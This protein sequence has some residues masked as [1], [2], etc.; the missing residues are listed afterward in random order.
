[1]PLEPVSYGSI[2]SLADFSPLAKIGEILQKQR[3]EDEAARLIAG[4][5][6]PQQQQQSGGF[7]SDLGR[8]FG[9]TAPQA[10]QP[11]TAAAPQA[12]PRFSNA[13]DLAANRGPNIQSWY[14]FARR[15]ADQGGLG[16]SHE[17]AV[18][19]VSNLQAESGAGI[20]A[21]GPTGDRGTAHGAAQWRLDRFANLQKFAQD[22]GLDYRD[23]ATQQ[24]FM[25]HEYLGSPDQGPGGGSE[26]SAYDRLAAA[27]TPQEAATAVNRYYERSADRTGGREANAARLAGTL[28]GGASAYAAPPT[29]NLPPEVAGGRSVANRVYEPGEASPFETGE[30]KSEPPQARI[31]N[32]DE[33]SPFETGQLTSEPPG[34]P[35]DVSAQS[36]AAPAANSVVGRAVNNLV[37]PEPTAAAGIPREQLAAL[38]RNPITRPLATAFL[39]KQLDPGSYSFHQVGDKLISSNSRTGQ[40]SVVMDDTKPFIVGEHALVRDPNSPTGFRDVAPPSQKPISVKEGEQLMV[41]D[42]NAPSGYRDITPGGGAG[43]SKIQR[44][45]RQ[46]TD[47]ALSKGYDQ[48]TADYYGL[49]GKLPK[50]DLSATEIKAISEAQKQVLSGQ[51][52]IDNLA[53]LK[54]LSP[55]AWSGWGATKRA[56]FANALLPNAMVP[57]GAVDAKELSNLALQNV[58]GQAKAMFGARL[59]VAEV[60][61]LNEI[62]TTPEMSDAERQRIYVRIERMIRRHVDAAQEEVE[63]IRNKTYFKPGGG[64]PSGSRS[65]GAAA[66]APTWKIVPGT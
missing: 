45:I 23:T 20:P 37:S 57:Q 25:R 52:V 35:T 14:E 54:E 8:Q 24:A 34:G 21:W 5:G 51:D 29:R 42:P 16:L 61:L 27:Q 36:R 58:V 43:V 26:R 50:E 7:F 44:E 55:T 41:A 63:G 22:R 2:S 10:A 48:P 60:K 17:Q 13:E 11:Q 33:A 39:Q 1:M 6:Q 49:N 15:P 9:L 18:G 46:R 32:P 64:G 28:G 56:S 62:E 47:E 4:L 19:K 40:T 65:D 12:V 59:A 31:Y 3:E 53:R 30:L 66:P 38:Y